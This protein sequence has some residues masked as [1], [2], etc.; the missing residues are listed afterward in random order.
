MRRAPLVGAGAGLVLSV[1]AVAAPT[2]QPRI[3]SVTFG[4]TQAKPTITIHGSHLGTRP[5][6]NPAYVPLSHPP[7]CPPAPTKPLPAY[8]YDYGTSLFLEERARKP[9]WS[10]G[11]YRPAVNELDCVGFVVVK[12]TPG[13][14]VLRLG[15]FYG[16]AKLQLAPND[17]FL[18]GVNNA[19]FHG[20]V[21][22]R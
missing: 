17:A 3:S 21:R 8:G 16:E 5:H 10:A 7:L 11:R 1:S 19:R 20:R 6:P 14:V 9:V 15:A 4:G 18:I 13:L 22:Y 2:A 12:F